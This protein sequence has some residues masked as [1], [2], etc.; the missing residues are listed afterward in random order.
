MPTR[1][2]LD[3]MPRFISH[4]LFRLWSG[5]QREHNS[6]FFGERASGATWASRIFKRLKRACDDI[7]ALHHF[8]GVAPKVSLH[9]VLKHASSR[10]GGWKPKSWY[11]GISSMSC[12]G[13]APRRLHLRWAD[14]ALFIW[15]YRRCPRI[16]DAVTIVRPETLLC[17]ASNGLSLRI[18]DGNPVRAVADH[19]SAKRC[20]I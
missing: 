13:G 17:V 18:G 11:C 7:V 14:R 12:S 10:G 8:N 20:A 4:S 15:L 3:R 19:G 16:L 1:R 6:I 9:T 2:V 5:A